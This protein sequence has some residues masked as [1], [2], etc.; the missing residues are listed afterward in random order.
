MDPKA[1]QKMMFEGMRTGMRTAFDTMNAI[2]EQMEKTWKV[3]LEQS[4]DARKDAENTLE[5]WLGNMRK[6]REEFRRNMDDGI[7]KME[8][9]MEQE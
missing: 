8:D 2:Q 9:L 3:F 4:G 6:G 1:T 7:R 5:E